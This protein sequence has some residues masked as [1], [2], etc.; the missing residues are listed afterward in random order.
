L[1]DAAVDAFSNSPAPEEVSILQALDELHISSTSQGPAKQAPRKHV[2][3][4]KRRALHKAAQAAKPKNKQYQQ[5]QTGRRKLPAFSYRKEVC[6]IVYSN[7]VTILSGDTGWYVLSFRDICRNFF[8]GNILLV[9][10]Y[11]SPSSTHI[12][13]SQLVP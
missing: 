11:F 5:M 6:D 8:V 4:P 10:L 7:R 3:I 1:T 9:R 2:D 12:H 13:T